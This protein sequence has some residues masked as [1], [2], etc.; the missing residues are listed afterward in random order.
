MSFI[1]E[2]AEDRANCLRHLGFNR[3]G[4]RPETSLR[5][6]KI[7]VRPILEYAS[8][9]LSYRHYYLKSKIDRGAYLARTDAYF[10]KL[11]A[12][13]NRVLKKLIPCPINTPPAAVRQFAGT[14]PMA[15]R[16]EILK[17]RYLWKISHA[18]D[19]NFAFSVNNNKKNELHKTKVGFTHEVRSVVNLIVLMCGRRFANQMRIL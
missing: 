8:Q 18:D 5:M 13:Q 19:I 15:A 10:Q 11:E 7:L 2:K 17:L 16:V 12:F 6:Y 4:L 9:V 1:L 14:M 3:D